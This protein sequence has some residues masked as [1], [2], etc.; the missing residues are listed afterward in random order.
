MARRFLDRRSG[1]VAGSDHTRSPLFCMRG[2]P[3]V[4]LGLVAASSIAV[5][6]ARRDCFEKSGEVAIRACSEAI[7][8]NPRDAVSY[9]NRGFEY[10]QKGDYVRS[11]G[12]YSKAIELDSRSPDAYQGRAWAYLRSGKAS[13]A[14]PDA[15]RSLQIKPGDARALDIRG[16]VLEALGRREDAIADYRRALAIE[17]RMKGSRDGLK[18][19]GASP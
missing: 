16:H 3:A 6:D 11:V 19:L 10:L 18:R 7:V 1:A 13:E 9:I 14:L 4:A 5:A 8:L 2:L 12:D 15:E 17:P